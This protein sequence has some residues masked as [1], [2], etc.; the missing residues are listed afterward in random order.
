MPAKLIKSAEDNL[1]DSLHELFQ[2][3]QYSNTYTYV[4]KKGDKKKCKN[5]QGISFLIAAYKILILC[6]RLKP[7]LS[8]IIGDYQCGAASDMVN[9]PS[10]C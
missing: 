3:S 1:I 5:Y 8:D 10:K 9:P 4:Y 6:E 7:Y 2:E